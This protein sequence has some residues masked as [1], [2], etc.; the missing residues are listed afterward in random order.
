MIYLKLVLSTIFWGASFTAGKVA[1][2]YLSIFSVAFFRFFISSIIFLIIIKRNIPHFNKNNFFV[3]FIG[4]FTGIFLYNIFFLKGL[5]LTEASKASIIVAIN[6]AITALITNLFLKEKLKF[7]NYTG[8][9]LSFAGLFLII[10]NGH[11]DKTAFSDLNYGD[12]LIVFAALSWSAYTI[13]GKIALN[14][15]SPMESTAYSIFWGTILLTPFAINDIFTRSLVFNLNVAISLI[16]L[17]VFATVLGFLWFYNGIKEIGATRASV[18]IYLVPFFGTLFG[19]II[20][21][22]QLTLFMILGG[23]LTIFGVYI[24]NKKY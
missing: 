14:T 10:T 11:F 16:V 15:L 18:F 21:H 5:G 1:V 4:G 6:P 24:T 9:I 7:L 19:V 2:A 13:F 3:C 22:E 20:L 23:L 17:S 8:L 12:I